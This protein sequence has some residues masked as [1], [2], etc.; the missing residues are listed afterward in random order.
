MRSG[1]TALTVTDLRKSQNHRKWNVDV[2]CLKCNDTIE[3]A[4]PYSADDEVGDEEDELENAIGDNVTVTPASPTPGA[5]SD[6]DSAVHLKHSEQAED[7]STTSSVNQDA[8]NTEEVIENGA[9]T[10]IGI[11]STLHSANDSVIDLI[12]PSEPVSFT[13]PHGK[14]PLIN[15][16]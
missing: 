12:N 3:L 4:K 8:A 6:N 13:P 10:S 2:I 16:L 7:L 11:N 14:R 9:T 5:S 15:I 1:E